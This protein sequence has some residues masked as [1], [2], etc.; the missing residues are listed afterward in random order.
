MADRPSFYILDA[1]SLIFQVFH[2]IPEMTGPSGQSTNAVFGIFRDLLNI[3][4]DRHPDYLAAAFDG[5]G[6]VFRSDIYA[7]YKA[8]RSA[9]P[10]L[11]VPQIDVIRRVFEGFNVPVL[12]EPGMEA[13]DV[14]ATLARRGE[15]RGL[16]VFICTSDKDAR[17]LITPHIKIINL[18]KNSIMD[19]EA[20]EKDWGIRPDQ[21]VDYLALTG[22]TVDNVPGVPGVGPVLAST[23][24]RQFGTLENLLANIDQVKGPKKQQILR[25]NVDVARRAKTLV[26]L[27]EDLPLVLDWDH[28]KM[29]PPNEPA[30]RALCFESGFHRFIAEI[31]G[32]TTTEAPA[33]PATEWK[34]EYRTIDTPE[35]FQSFV[36]E[37]GRQERFCIDTETTALDPLRAS[38]VGIAISWKAGEG[39]Y[40]PLRGPI[41]YRLLDPA[42]VLEGLRP[43]LADPKIEKVG[44]NIKY[45]MLALGRAGVSI[46][47]PITDTMILSY[48]LESGERNH[49]LDQLSQRLLDHTMIPISDLIGKGKNQARMDQIDVPRVTEYAGEDADATWRIYEILAPQ[50]RE[51]GLW[52]LY[53]D[54]ERPLISILA[55]MEAIGVKVDVEKLETLSRDFAIRLATIEEEVHRLAGRPFNINSVPQLRQILFEELKL[56]KLQKTPGGELS[57]ATEVLEELATKHPLPALLVQHRQLSKLKGTYLDALPLLVHPDDGRIHASFNQGV[58]ATGRLSSSDPNLQ[59]IPVRTE[60]GRQ[61]RQAFIAGADDW[62]LLTADYSQ[63]ELRILAHYSE[64]PALQRA[65]AADHDIHRAVASR[66]YGVAESDVDSAMRRVAKTVNFGVIYGL[67][68]FGLASRLGLKQ[69]EAAAFI[70]A[71]FKEYEGVDRFITRTLETARDAGRVETILGRRRPIAGIK[72]TTGRN[73]NLAERTAVNTVIQGSAADLI[74][75][76]MIQ[77]DQ[78]LRE[79]GFEA[80]MILQIHDE[81][82]FETPAAEVARLAGLV[83]TEMTGAMAL[84][85]PLKVDLAVGRNW[86]DVESLPS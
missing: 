38:L 84:S 3:A 15:E 58:A 40:I 75:R 16:D 60:E 1:Y 69:A 45:D 17:Q 64:D 61:I 24:L 85:V 39:Y 4:R 86:L 29:S 8:N 44:Q 9:M 57:T 34:A 49:S 82:V 46:E 41:G 13:D 48:L 5:Q 32:A 67:S 72:T 25:D 62:R 74:K 68:P 21:V 56:P 42:L 59:N 19:A 79:G 12:V 37:L 54:L 66:I 51:Q 76:A 7:E 20:L 2:A 73:R 71:Y 78:R 22:D 70:D 50:V 35:S 63:I 83:R 10:D 33:K 77:V 55:R 30:L 36:A 43:I 27:R 11:L 47:G 81:L 26:A 53:A 31:G 28:L 6:P 52:D 23:Y 14:I 80:R 18:R 65:F